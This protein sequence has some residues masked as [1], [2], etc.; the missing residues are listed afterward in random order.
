MVPRQ[1]TETLVEETLAIARR[2]FRD[3]PCSIAD[4]GTGSGCI[5]V[6]LAVHLPQAV[7]YAIDSDAAALEVAALNAK[8]HGVEDRVRFLHG[9][10]LA[11]LR[12]PVH[13]VVS[14]LPYVPE[15]EWPGLQPEICRYEPKQALVPGPTGLEANLRLLEHV[16]ALRDGPQWLLLEAGNGQPPVLAEQARRMLPKATVR[17]YRDLAGL[18][19]G[20]VIS[21]AGRA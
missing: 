17:L 13:I 2:E 18:E 1:E 6:S 11:P 3:G 5:A 21:L 10:L 19:R 12:E 9:D 16:A 15:T 14:N 20:L 8:R 7:I 4:V